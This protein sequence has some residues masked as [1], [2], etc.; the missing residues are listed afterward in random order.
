MPTVVAPY[1][2]TNRSE[3]QHQT[4]GIL[5]IERFTEVKNT[6][7]YSRNRLHRT[8]NRSHGAAAILMITVNSAPPPFTPA[9]I[10]VKLEITVGTSAI[11]KTFTA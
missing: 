11:S 6:H 2:Q 1:D 8:E 4:G 10:S 7:Q 9:S 3:D 5:Q